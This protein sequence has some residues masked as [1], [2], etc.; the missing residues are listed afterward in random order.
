MKPLDPR[1]RTH[2]EP[3]RTQL[4]IGVAA[5]IGQTALVVGQAFVLTGAL[6]AVVDQRP[7]TRW[8]VA[9]GAVVALRALATPLWV[10]S[11][12]RARPNGSDTPFEGAW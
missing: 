3:A 4:V 9:L 6:V 7:V 12:R 1:V 8:A 5:G 11:P 2:L 10:T